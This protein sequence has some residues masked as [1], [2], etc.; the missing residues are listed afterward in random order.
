MWQML[1]FFLQLHG[2][3]YFDSGVDHIE[4]GLACSMGKANLDRGAVFLIAFGT[5]FVFVIPAVVF[6]IAYSR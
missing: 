3:P 4:E 1:Q 6:P 2:V 5:L